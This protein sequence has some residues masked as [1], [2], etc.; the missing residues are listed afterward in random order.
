MRQVACAGWHEEAGLDAP[1]GVRLIF[2]PPDTPELQPAQTLGDWSTS[3]SPTNMSQRSRSWKT[4]SQ[5]DA[6][7]WPINAQPSK[8]EPDSI[9]AKN[10]QS[11]VINRVS[12]ER[13]I[14]REAVAL[15]LVHERR[16]ALPEF[17]K[18]TLGKAPARKVGI[19][20]CNP[21]TGE[22]SLLRGKVCM[23]ARQN[24]PAVE[25]ES[26]GDK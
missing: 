24:P 14:E 22:W 10:H 13:S 25:T 4:S 7:L 19:L 8:A 26:R 3:R 9:G 16:R 17:L 21:A 2:M 23:R 15:V 6:S 12:Y 11:E 18:M 5:N 20:V 1:D